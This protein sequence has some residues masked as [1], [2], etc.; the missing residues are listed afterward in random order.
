M[1]IKKLFYKYLF[2]A[3]ILLGTTSF[4]HPLKFTASL[5]DYDAN[6]KSLK[7]ECRVFIDDFENCI[8]KKLAKDISI[9]N[10]SKADKDAIQKYFEEYYHITVNGKKIPLKYKTSE[11]LKDYNVFAIKFSDN[12]LTMKKGDKLL[13]ENTL[14]FEEFSY[15]QSNRITV[16]IPPFI[17]EDYF[18]A[19][20]GNYIIPIHL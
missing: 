2:C 7:M 17:A 20:V 9:S 10:L 12:N 11:V 18:E 16:R 19:T 8:N 15:M 3:L 4:T 13:I 5:I 6:T 14:F 1:Q